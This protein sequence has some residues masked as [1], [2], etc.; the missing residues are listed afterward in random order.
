MKKTDQYLI[1]LGDIFLNKE[2]N[3]HQSRCEQ[4]EYNFDYHGIEDALCGKSFSTSIT[5][6]TPKRI[7][8][9]QMI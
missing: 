8:V 7:I 4:D 2:N 9:I 5:K 1:D 6:I 3:K